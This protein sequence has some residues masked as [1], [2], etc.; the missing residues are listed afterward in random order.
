MDDFLKTA[1]QKIRAHCRDGLPGEPIAVLIIAVDADGNEVSQ[2]I[3]EDHPDAEPLARR[4]A[5][6]A[7][8]DF[9]CTMDGDGDQHTTPTGVT[10]Q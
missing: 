2:V 8:E 10:L 5:G 6:T 4:A 7:S 1:F 3:T 9:L